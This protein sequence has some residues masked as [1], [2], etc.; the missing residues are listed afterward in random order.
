LCKQ[1]ELYLKL[2]WERVTFIENS[3]KTSNEYNL[4]ASSGRDTGAQR[5]AVKKKKLYRKR[6][7]TSSPHATAI[8]GRQSKII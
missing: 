8:G 6:L 1:Q 5:G 4:Q 3:K 2:G 7:K